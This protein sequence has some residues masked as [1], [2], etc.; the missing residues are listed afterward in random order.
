MFLITSVSMGIAERLWQSIPHR[1]GSPWSD[2]AGKTFD[3]FVDVLTDSEALLVFDYAFL[4]VEAFT[5]NGT[6]ICHPIIWSSDIF[7]NKAEILKGFLE[8]ATILGVITLS[9]M[10]PDSSQS[11]HRLA[12]YLDFTYTSPC[13]MPNG[14]PGSIYIYVPRRT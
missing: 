4:R 10:I 14:E 5:E 6:A 2:E 11:L 9:F 3:D 12:R 1:P 13:K 8:L 7:R